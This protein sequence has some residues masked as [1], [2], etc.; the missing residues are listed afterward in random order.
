MTPNPFEAL[1]SSVEVGGR[2]VP[3]EPDF[4]VGVAIELEAL[5]DAPD[6]EGLL[7]MFYPGGVP[8]P[9]SQAAEQM[10]AFYAGA[11]AGEPRQGS[12]KGG[13]AY[14]FSQDADALLASFLDAYGIDL[15]TARLHWWSF[16]R[17]MLNLPPET[18]FMRRVYY[19]TADTKKM[20]REERKQVEKMRRQY[21][22]RRAAGPEQS[23]EELEKALRDKVNR[24]FE[25]AQRL[26]GQKF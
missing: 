20:S 21:A 9:A 11:D 5:S 26:V 6:I 25:E 1:P 24:R 16:R 8:E 14:D 22:L 10:L 18:P 2:A 15:S 7:R 4:R 3:I 13:R 17:L 23:P 19:R 12:A